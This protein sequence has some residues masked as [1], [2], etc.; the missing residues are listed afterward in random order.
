MKC[1]ELYLQYRSVKLNG[2][3]MYL[4]SKYYARFIVKNFQNKT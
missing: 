2:G 4:N 1:Q 3:L